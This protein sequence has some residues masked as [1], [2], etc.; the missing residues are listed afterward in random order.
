M[1][2]T[3][4][5]ID[6]LSRKVSSPSLMSIDQSIETMKVPEKYVRSPVLRRRLSTDTWT[7]TG[8]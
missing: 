7:R 2:F 5:N 4:S 1:M 8:M 6:V 3:H